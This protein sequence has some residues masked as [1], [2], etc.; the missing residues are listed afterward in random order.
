MVT[1]RSR[2]DPVPYVAACGVQLLASASGARDGVR[3]GGA[4]SPRF[5]ADL[6]EGDGPLPPG[7]NGATTKAES[8]I[9]RA[10]RCPSPAARAP[11]PSSAM[12]QWLR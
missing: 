3:R 6:A 2:N 12:Y 8:V 9:T 5:C 10:R 7:M 4:A 1:G 11:C